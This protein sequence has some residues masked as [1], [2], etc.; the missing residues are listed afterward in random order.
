MKQALSILIALLI[1]GFHVQAGKK[2]SVKDLKKVMTLKIDRAGGANA[3]AVVWHPQLQRYYA[4]QAG[5]AAFPLEI[6]DSKGTMISDDNL[7]T[8]IDIRGLWYNAQRKTLQINAYNDLGWAEY[9]M[10]S[11]GIPEGVRRMPGATGQPT[12]NSAA[13]YDA[14]NDVVYFFDNAASTL[15]RHQILNSAPEAKIPL[16]L[17]AATKD[18]FEAH[19]KNEHPEYYNETVVVYT[20]NKGAEVGMLNIT[21]RRIELYDIGTGYMTQALN[22]P[23]DATVEASLDF[24]YANEIYWLFDTKYREWKGYKP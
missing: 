13:A 7:A 2:L 8:M 1:M 19:K 18:E 14:V 4:A 17:G 24:S 6:F 10:N 3:A 5:N 9:K 12:E 23:D 11:N 16:Y 21:S 22:L 20:G 15:N